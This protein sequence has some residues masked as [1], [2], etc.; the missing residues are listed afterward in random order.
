MP[1]H[2][3]ERDPL[4]GSQGA[5]GSR[6]VGKRIS[7]F[8]GVGRDGDLPLSMQMVRRGQGGLD[9]MPWF[10]GLLSKEAAESRIKQHGGQNQPGVYLV[11]Q[12]MEG[13]YILVLSYNG[14]A[15]EYLIY[16]HAAN[17][18]SIG[19]GP[20]LPLDQLLAA[21]E[22]NKHGLP[23]R[24]HR[25]CPKNG[26][27]TQSF[28]MPGLEEETAFG[29]GSTHHYEPYSQYESAEQPA[30]H[31]KK[32]KKGH[33]S[34]GARDASG[35]AESSGSGNGSSKGGG[36]SKFEIV[37]VKQFKPYF[38]YGV[39]FTQFALLCV[40]LFL[41]GF[42]TIS[43][44]PVEATASVTMGFNQSMVELTTFTPANIFIGP[45]TKYLVS[46]GAKYNPCMRK[47]TQIFSNL[48]KQ[49]QEEQSLGCCSNQ[50]GC[51]MTTKRGCPSTSSF[52]GEGVDCDATC[53][54]HIIGPCCTQMNG[55]CEL[56]TQD[57]CSFVS[58]V[59]HENATLCSEVSC[60]ESTC[61][62]SMKDPEQ[63][64]QWY[65]F[66]TSLF[67]HAGVLHLVFTEAIVSSYGFQVERVCGWFRMAI[68]YTI[69][70]VGGNVVSAIFS[71]NFPQVGAGGAAVGIVG[72]KLVDTLHSWQA[73]ES[74]CKQLF[75]ILITL[76]IGLFVGTLPYVDN[77]AHI[78]GFVFGAVSA[79]VFLPYVTF[80]K[81]DR[82][83]KRCLLFFCMPL[84]VA[85]FLVGF[86]LFYNIQFTYACLD[87]DYIQCIEY[88]ENLCDNVN[89]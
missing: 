8:F 7:Q 24:L 25:L 55:T 57:Y 45:A 37:G 68:M 48:A 71:P 15:R 28:D 70:G 6:S 11:R 56:V 32:K 34:G 66:L 78:G 80:G 49:K 19:N 87:C 14:K 82:V 39:L 84:L 38:M 60:L 75:G 31:K 64:N 83:R 65:R 36:K 17:N 30:H 27:P 72:I 77:W 79:I 73:L 13:E 52:A 4:V 46:F 51:G 43:L 76:T 58:G 33:K 44:K 53:G 89:F 47:D 85:L 1:R 74:P 61:G 81:W 26:K 21:H 18:W 29:A 10:H 59:W 63:P 5:A 50:E 12:S 3:G 20:K 86:V 35:G 23:C 41:S 69:A 9:G 54:H 88:V 40:L 62:M 42:N 16:Q 22:T 2:R 67:L